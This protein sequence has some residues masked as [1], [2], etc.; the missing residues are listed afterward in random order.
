MSRQSPFV[1]IL[2]LLI[3]IFCWGSVFPVSKLVLDQMS[4]NSLV[5]W[6][7]SIAAL[8]LVA[9]LLVKRE[10]WP[11]LSFKQYA[12]LLFISLIGVGGFNLLLFTGV[13]HTAATNGALVMALSPLVTA[14][15]VAALSRKWLSRTQ[16]LSLS[17]G[18]AG[19]LLV[20]TKGSWQTLAQFQFNQGDLT[21]IIAMLLWSAYTTASQKVTGWLPLLPF[22]LVSML[23][24]DAFILAFNSIQGGIHP[25]TELLQLPLQGIMAVIYI[26]VF[27]T[28]VGY[29]F[30][31]NAVQRLGSAPAAL[32]FNLIPVC[33][34]LTAIIMGQTVTPVQISGMA[35]VLCGLMLPQLM[36]L[37]RPR[38][39]EQPCQS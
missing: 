15:M 19:V 3:S 20:I 23:A 37:L 21:I 10:R 14:L 18:L 8:C 2:L 35:I 16:A 17:I 27:G 13:K 6:R 12:W 39:A 1:T 33:A 32:F 4:Q 34:A 29:V 30:F 25:V 7:F 5:V 38:T 36:K 31:L 24:G 9:C 26:G 22:T 28:V 11:M